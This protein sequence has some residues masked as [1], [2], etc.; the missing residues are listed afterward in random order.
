MIYGLVA[1]ALWGL[2]DLGT[3]VVA[4]RTGSFRTLVIAQLTAT[5]LLT[6]ILFAGAPFGNLGSAVWALPLAGAFATLAYFGLYKGLELGPVALVS[7]ITAAYAAV[8]VILAVVI[9]HET[10]SPLAAAGAALTIAGVVVATTS[11]RALRMKGTDEPFGRHGITYAVMSMLAFGITTFVIGYYSGK[12]GWF[13][14][15]YLSRLGTAA[16]LTVM[17]AMGG[18]RIPWIAETV[19]GRVARTTVAGAAAIGIADVVG[20]LSFARG[21]QLGYVAIA[22][23]ASAVFPL[24]PIA[25]G[26]LVFGERPAPVQLAGVAAVIG[27]LVLLG[28]GH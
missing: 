10:L 19:P 14:P 16:T 22:A 13:A 7:P 18:G 3:A 2:A 28:L 11:P 21:G 8:T 27:G 6:V 20:L 15:V 4:R 12:T 17:M 24:V 5:L 23:A 25:G 26:M 1:A 9:L